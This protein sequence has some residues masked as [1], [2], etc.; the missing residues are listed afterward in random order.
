M[1]K[2]LESS[3]W[4][5]MVDWALG[6]LSLILFYFSS[7][8][9]IVLFI[10]VVVGY[11]LHETFFLSRRSRIDNFCTTLPELLLCYLLL[12][13]KSDYIFRHKIFQR[14]LNIKLLMWWMMDETTFTRNSIQK[15]WSTAIKK[16]LF[17]RVNVKHRNVQHYVG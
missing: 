11:M 15:A 2:A 17:A 12:K 16:K 6:K 9:V 13:H 7:K 8:L 5:R 4:M 3:W 1:Y 10:I 14:I